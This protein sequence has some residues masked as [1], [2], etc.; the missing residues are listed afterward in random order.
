MAI[1][2]KPKSS[3]Q[4]RAE[5]DVEALINRGGGVAPL[6][7]FESVSEKKTASF[8]L[9]VAPGTLAKLDRHLGKQPYKIP[10]QQWILEAV[11]QR[12]ERESPEESQ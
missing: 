7:P 3:N 5:V 8:T 1:A 6:A 11:L 10:R 2:R 9:R 4:A 12:L